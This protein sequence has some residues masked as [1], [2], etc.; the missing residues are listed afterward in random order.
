M[1]WPTSN[2][3]AR[4]MDDFWKESQALW[5][6][7][8]YEADI[9]TKMMTGQQ[10]LLN[11][12]YNINYRNQKQLMFNKLLRIIN[13]IG[14]Y[15]RKNRLASVVY[16]ADNDPDLGVTAEQLTKVTEWVKRQDNTYEKIS[17]CFDGSNTCG[18]NLMQIWLDHREDPENGQIRTMRIPFNAFLMDNYWTQH[19]L[20]DCDRIWTRR[21]L[22]DRQL[23][24]IKPDIKK[25]LSSLGK[26]YAAKDGKFQFLAQNWYQYSQQMYAYDEYWVRDYKT[27]RKVLD[28]VTGELA[29]WNGTREQFQRFRE[30]NPNIELIK[31]QVPTVKLHCLVNNNLVYEEKEPYGLSRFPFVP[32]MCYHFT[33]VQNYSYRYQGVIRNCRDSQI[34]LNRRRNKL[35][36]ILDAQVQSGIMVKEDALVNPEDGFMQGPGKVMFFKNTANLATDVVPFNAPPVAQGWEE[37][38]KT[39]DNEIMSIVGTPEELF[40]EDMNGKDMSGIMMKLK[41]GAGLTSLQNIFDRLNESQR[42]V[43]D[44]ILEI[45]QKNF[46]SGKIKSIIG[47][48]PSPE[49]NEAWKTK[50]HCV[51]EEA[52][53]TDS[54]KQLQFLQALHLKELGIPL[55]NDYLVELSNIQG[56]KKV[57]EQLKKAQQQQQAMEQAQQQQMLQQGEILNRSIEAKAQAD[58]SHAKTYQAEAIA[59]ISQAKELSSKAQAERA[60]ATLS[61]VK[62]LKEL[63]EM[64]DD[65]LIKVSQFIIGLEDRERAMAKQDEEDSDVDASRAGSGVSES[66]RNSRPSPLGQSLQQ[67]PQ[68]QPQQPF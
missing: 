2:P 55:D 24:S 49:F 66:E 5:Q 26:G 35:L 22:T 45:V 62:T 38:I 59:K 4:E 19:D 48:E 39:L 43:S 56:K 13:M 53:M 41:M 14:G 58:F 60:A 47:E 25:D 57:M 37:L 32:F 31:A 15:Q 3:I 52:A 64:D 44:I 63:R 8:W 68:G 46:G 33:E 6:Q 28:R 29:P 12:A 42:N 36:D 23:L 1:T 27:V 67:Q 30:Y 34:E 9:D 21:Y 40:G 11:A 51:I 16:P 50:Y 7:W 65:R 20:S 10:D 61:Q 18:L 17:Q 54:Q